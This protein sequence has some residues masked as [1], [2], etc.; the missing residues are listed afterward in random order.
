MAR[1]SAKDYLGWSATGKKKR[2]DRNDLEAVADKPSNGKT[3]K[4]ARDRK[5]RCLHDY[6]LQWSD[7]GYKSYRCSK[8]AKH[9]FTKSAK[10]GI[11]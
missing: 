10:G 1:L 8:C 2:A 5:K 3:H 11:L 9:K 6:V 4:K 7:W